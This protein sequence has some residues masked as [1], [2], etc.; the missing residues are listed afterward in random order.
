MRFGISC[1]AA[2]FLFKRRNLTILW[3]FEDR[4]RLN[5]QA[6]AYRERKHHVYRPRPLY[7]VL[8]ELQPQPERTVP[9]RRPRIGRYRR[10]PL[11]HS[12]SRLERRAAALSRVIQG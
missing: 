12:A 8:E 5:L 11:G 10:Q 3:V 7:P 9:A 4:P 1:S 2:K 6:G